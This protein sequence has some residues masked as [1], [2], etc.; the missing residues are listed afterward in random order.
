MRE[1]PRRLVPEEKDNPN[2]L[3]IEEFA[4]AVRISEWTARKWLREER[5]RGFKLAGG[6]EWRIPRDEITYIRG[7]GILQ[8]SWNT[9]ESF[10]RAYREIIRISDEGRNDRARAILFLIIDYDEILYS[11]CADV[12]RLLK[13]HKITPPRSLREAKMFRLEG[14]RH[15]ENIEEIVATRWVE[16]DMKAGGFQDRIDYYKHIYKQIIENEK[17]RKEERKRK[18]SS[19]KPKS[20]RPK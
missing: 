6:K 10:A 11:L 2:L 18:S 15:I 5:I 4:K 14:I 3:T 13:K 12:E 20:K 1:K 7:Q 9:R 8:E 19:R 17:K 16:E